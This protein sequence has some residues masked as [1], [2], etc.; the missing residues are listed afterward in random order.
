M[1]SRLSTDYVKH[2]KNRIEVVC[3]LKVSFLNKHHDPPI[4]S[5]P[6]WQTDVNIAGQKFSR[7]VFLMYFCSNF[8]GIRISNVGVL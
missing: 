8:P 6:V 5:L 4:K 7:L 2:D 1:V 3:F